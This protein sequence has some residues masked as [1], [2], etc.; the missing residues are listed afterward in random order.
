MADSTWAEIFVPTRYEA[1]LLNLAELIVAKYFY[2]NAFLKKAKHT[3]D[4]TITFKNDDYE[5]F[6]F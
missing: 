1:E 3:E 6:S 4:N 5:Y 2:K